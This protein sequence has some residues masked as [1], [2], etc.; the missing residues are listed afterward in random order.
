MDL[1]PIVARNKLHTRSRP[2]RDVTRTKVC[3][4]HCVNDLVW[5]H[6][7]R[8]QEASQGESSVASVRCTLRGS[9]SFLLVQSIE[10]TPSHGLLEDIAVKSC[11]GYIGINTHFH[12]QMIH[13]TCTAGTR[14]T[15]HL[16][17]WCTLLLQQ[18]YSV[19]H[20][21]LHCSFSDSEHEPNGNIVCIL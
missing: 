17:P 16:A 21:N 14:V 4:I 10:C 13:V 15:K 6:T 2:R 20:D 9:N 5:P 3:L 19:S 1:V 12:A 11:T 18:A 7:R 8:Q